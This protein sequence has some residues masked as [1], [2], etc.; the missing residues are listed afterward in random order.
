MKKSFAWIGSLFL[1][2]ALC[3]WAQP[4]A[5]STKLQSFTTLPRPA[6]VTQHVDDA[7]LTTLVGGTHPAAIAK[8][9]RGRVSDQLQMEH[10]FLQLK[11]SPV[12]EKEL[13]QFID[14]LHDRNSPNYHKWITSDEFGRRF[15]IAQADIDA[16]SNWLL[17][18]GFTVN[19]MYPNMV[20]DF[21]GTAGQI[22]SA[23]HTEIHNLQVNGETHIAN[24][25]N[26]QIP[27]ALAPAVMGMLSLHDF[28]P[29]PHNH[30]RKDYTV[31]SGT[32]LVTPSDLHTIY[33]FNPVYSG[34]HTGTGQTIAIMSES[35]VYNSTGAT[36]DWNVFRNVLGIPVSTYTHAS[37]T[38]V[39]PAP[40]A[41]G[42]CSDPGVTGAEG[43]AAIDVEWSAAAAP[44]AAIV[45]ASCKDGASAGLFIAMQNLLTNGSA[46]PNIISISYGF[47]EPAYGTAGNAYIRGLYQVAVTAGISVFVS[48]GDS[49]ADAADQNKGIDSSGINVSGFATTPYNVA[50]GGTDYSDF[51]SGTGSTYWNASNTSTYGSAKSYIPEIP[52]N[53]SCGS[54]LLANYVSGSTLTYGSGGFCNIASGSSY[55]D[56][57]GGSGGPSACASGS[58]GTCAGYPKPGWQA[59][60]V[61]NPADGVRDIPDVAL[62]AADGLWG[63]YYVVCWSD[64]ANQ[65]AA[66]TGAPSGWAGFGGTSVAA[67]I[68]AGIQAL[69][70]QTTGDRWGNPNPVY[71][72]L[73]KTEYGASGSSTCNSSL[74]NGVNSSCI[75]YDVTLGDMDMP[76]SA[77]SPNCYRP[78]GTNGVLST[79]TSAYQPAYKTNTGWDFPTGIGTVNVAN[80]VSHFGTPTKAVI[81]KPTPGSKFTGA[82]VTFQW[83]YGTGV[84]QYT[85]YVGTTPG[86]HDLDYIN[87]GLS[88]AVTVNNMPTNA[89]TVY[90]TLYSRINGAYQTNSYTYLAAGTATPATMTTPANG[91]KLTGA[92]QTFN[93][94]AGSGVTQYSLY[95]GS[96]AGAHDIDF[97]NAHLNHSATMSNLPTDGRGIYVTLYS[98]IGGSYYS[99][100]YLY[101]A[102]GT[103]V[104]AAMTTPAN[105]ATLTGSNVT[106]NWS[107]GTGV[108]SYS[109][110]VGTSLGAH[111]LDYVPT[112]SHSASITNLPHNGSTVYVRLY[113]L[114]DGAWQYNDYTYTSNP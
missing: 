114:I 28:R 86:G 104:K 57:A 72:S 54:Q 4:P 25:S 10:I 77:G 15:G 20:I 102:A 36:S 112:T 62:F 98:V 97:I 42:A 64:T 65:G 60:L 63:H 92:S 56:N 46:S 90:V 67:P 17:N 16:V 85:L 2:G 9:D 39:H 58:G 80:L 100:S 78:S 94:S 47:T 79:S 95:I 71:Y 8:S 88:T 109:V 55:V 83:S 73:A 68:W 75:F 43:E 12:Q 7:K 101:S 106:F 19:H 91:A 29:T 33:N 108:T 96:T 41:G 110:Y 45:L 35:N 87:A 107:A 5:G 49:G 113:S 6:L 13:E 40:G 76:C 38:T 30:V 21:S 81:T 24:M 11:R 22:N 82:G 18:H 14:S 53:D 61:G 50:V 52:W 34:G 93:W 74:G 84:E 111:N 31:G 26:P 51:Y 70:D 105:H 3:S 27:A 32:Y 99:H 48:S 69:V 23:F 59:S 89:S 1:A 103:P 66:C 37:L 44:D